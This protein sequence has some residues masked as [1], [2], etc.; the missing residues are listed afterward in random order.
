MTFENAMRLMTQDST[1]KLS[2]TGAT[3]CYGSSLMTCADIVKLTKEKFYHI[4][5]LEF[6]EMIGRVA[7]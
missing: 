7:H 5:F 1:I 4:E 2:V 6:M 3:I